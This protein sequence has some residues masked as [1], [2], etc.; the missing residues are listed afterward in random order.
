[1]ES[2]LEQLNKNNYLIIDNFIE[3]EYAKQL[4]NMFKYE[5]ENNPNKFDRDSYCPKSYAIHNHKLF[6]QI[7][8]SKIPHIS[9]I[10]EQLVFPTYTYA[11]HY[12]N[13][14]VLEKHTDREQCELSITLHLDSDKVDWPICFTKP[15]GE[16]VSV[17]MKPGQAILYNAMI[18]EHWRDE[19]LGDSYSQVFLHYVRSQGKYW[20]E[21]FDF[22]FMRRNYGV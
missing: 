22:Q 13:G 6:L 16:P 8:V 15:N 21:Y 17:N 7:L 11:R 10:V 5:V 20:Q 18:S 2:Q 19:Y 3:P 1:M 9:D 14:E 4:H 12:K